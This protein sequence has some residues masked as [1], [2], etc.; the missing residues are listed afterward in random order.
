MIAQWDQVIA[1]WTGRNGL[2]GMI[3]AALCAA[4]VVACAPRVPVRVEPP[5]AG[6]LPTA[7]ALRAEVSARRQQVHTLRALARFTYASPEETRRAKQ[8]LL[9]SRPNRLRFEILSPFGSAF[10]FTS[11]D[12]TFA[13]YA[14]G[15]D[16]IYRG[17]ASPENLERYIRI[18]VPVS[19]AVD[20]LLGTPPLWSDAYD[21][22][23]RDQSHIQL[24][25]A[26]NADHEDV[27][28]TWFTQ[29]LDP[30]RYEE[31]DD[32]GRVLLRVSFGEFAETA[33]GRFPARIGIELPASQQ[34]I[35]I[36][37]LEPEINPDLS[38]AMFA[39]QT[40]PGT[41]EVDLDRIV[42]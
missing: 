5:I 17:T 1:T 42:H 6:E 23:S 8:V 21:V 37:L 18:E 22:V 33:G 28:V 29:R 11:R 3:C 7:E 20:L 41:K 32:E 39:L 31:R 34:H 35:E 14:H 12:G 4:G 2:R 40:P 9:V 15:E 24:W 38:E 30:T 27:R 13:A 10:V 26:N 25:Q 36:E 19:S 16:T